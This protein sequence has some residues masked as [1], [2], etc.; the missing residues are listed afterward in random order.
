MTEEKQEGKASGRINLDS[1]FWR[2]FLTI[3]AALLTFACPTYLVYVAINV[4]ELNYF[5]S[6]ISGFL[7][8]LVGLVLVWYLIKNKVIV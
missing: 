4:L 5:V 1:K 6:M 7:L 3:L 2:T 8:F